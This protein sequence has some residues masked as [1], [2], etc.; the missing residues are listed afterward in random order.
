M[1]GDARRDSRSSGPASEDLGQRRSGAGWQHA[2][3]DLFRRAPHRIHLALHDA[4]ARRRDRD[5]NAG[6]RGRVSQAAALAPTGRSREARD[7]AH[8][9]ARALDRVAGSNRGGRDM[10]HRTGVALL[11]LALVCM[12][13]PTA[14]ETGELRFAKQ[15][16][17]GYVQFNILER[18]KLIEKHARALGLGEVKVSC[19]TF[20]G[21]DAMNTAL[22][23]GDVD[24]VAGGVP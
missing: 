20:N 13:G 3:H 5:R 7:L 14:A 9:R 18:Q 10:N 8:R 2:R 16:S 19:V 15:T 4:R 6:G 12:T 24:I 23:A 21:P 1:A 22:L 17:M 11:T